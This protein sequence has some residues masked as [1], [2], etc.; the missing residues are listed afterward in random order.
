MDGR[1]RV[2]QSLKLPEHLAGTDLDRPD[3]GDRALV[4][5]TTGGLQVDDDE[6]HIAKCGAQIIEGRLNCLHDMDGRAGVRQGN[7]GALGGSGAPCPGPGRGAPEASVGASSTVIP[8]PYG[9]QDGV[10]T[11]TSSGTFT[12]AFGGES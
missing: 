6:R 7:A 5:A 8:G 10:R 1:A 4:R 12:G 11:G 2:D 9:R 3:L